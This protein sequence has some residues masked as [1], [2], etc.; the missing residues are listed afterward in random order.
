MTDEELLWADSEGVEVW[1]TIHAWRALGQLRAVEA[2]KPLLSQL[3]RIDDE[4]DDWIGEEFPDVFS[5]IGPPAIP[6]LSSYLNTGYGLFAKVCVAG[7]IQQIGNKYPDARQQCIEILTGRLGNFA[8]NDPTLNGFLISNLV[9]LKAVDSL[10]TV[11]S[12][13]KS[14]RVDPSILGDI[15]DVE[16]EL[17][18][19]DSRSS[20]PPEFEWIFDGDNRAPDNT[21]IIRAETKIG[22]N[23]PC[24]CG[25]GK[26]FKKCCLNK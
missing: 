4:D 10:D 17:G 24:P 2:I 11:R 23:E 22:R 1:A 12:A 5:L 8:K 15:E 20:P 7:C 18:V 26:K 25:S 21:T 6:S 9:D 16:I 13:Y 3:Y 19:R 14:E